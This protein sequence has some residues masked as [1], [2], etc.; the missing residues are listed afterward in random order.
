MFGILRT[1]LAIYVVLLHIF[2]FPTLGNYAVSFFFI[3]SGFLMTYVM[4]KSYSYDFSGVKLF[5][6]NRFLRLYPTYWLVLLLSL[7]AIFALSG[8]GLNP[9]M[10]F[11]S[12]FKEWVSN[13]SMLYFDIV[14]HRIKPRVVP[15]SWALT[16]ELVFYLL[17]SF[18]ISKNKTRTFIWLFFSI[19]YY[20]GT[21]FFYDLPT[22]RYSAIPASSLP[23]AIGAALFWLNERQT[24]IKGNISLII[25]LMLLFNVNAV[26]LANTGITIYTEISIY[27]NYILSAAIVLLLFQVKSNKKIKQA[28]NFIGYFSYP[29]YLSHYLIC[30]VY[31]YFFN[32]NHGTK[33]YKLQTDALIG[34]FL[35]LFVFCFAIVYFIDI[36]I[37]RYKRELQ[38]AR[39]I[40]AN[41]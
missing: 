19:L 14:P 28:D 6:A 11:P 38:L 23:F 5:W 12:S 29:I 10:Y 16:N 36:R 24:K 33:A 7:V 37:D 2:S 18:G 13:I 17:I 20:V 22:F 9:A 40:K 27:T 30:A 35:I 26:Y 32:P 4:Q 1:L 15:T 8:N 34:Y 31:I 41:N 21:Y 3:L 25:F 39:N